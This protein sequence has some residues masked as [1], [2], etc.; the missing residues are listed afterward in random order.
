VCSPKLVGSSIHNRILN[1]GDNI[2]DHLAIMCNFKPNETI[3]ASKMNKCLLSKLQWDNANLGLYQAVLC[4]SL[5][6]IS[7]PLDALLCKQV[8]CQRHS[9]ELERYYTDIVGCLNTAAKQCVPASK[10]GL[11][12]L[13]WTPELDELKQQF[14]DVCV[15]WA[16]IGRP[17]SG[18]INAE[19]LKCNY[20]YKRAVQYAMQK[21][22]KQFNDKLYDHLCE[23]TRL[24][25]GKLGVNG[26]VLTSCYPPIH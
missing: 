22:D 23:R 14:I 12:K 16:S 7:L 17:H 13:R 11:Q 15:L 8:D 3:S 20:R 24:A 25:S 19:R 4:D 2:S 1:H 5:A 6:S 26:F 18:S 10:P 21:N 9:V